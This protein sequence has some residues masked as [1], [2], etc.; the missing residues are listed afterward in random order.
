MI[1]ERVYA[2]FTLRN[3]IPVTV[4]HDRTSEKSSCS[5]AVKTGAMYDPLPGIAHITE[6]AVFLGSEKYPVENAYK[7]F[8]NK[9]G[10]SSNAGTSMEHT[11]YKFAV[12]QA[13]FDKALDIFSQFFKSPLFSTEAMCREIMA[14]D[15]EDSKNRIIDSRRLLQVLKHQV[16]PASEYAKFSTGNLKTLVY[17]DVEK[18]GNN[19][20]N[21]I[22]SFHEEHYLPEHM[23]VALV[24]PQSVEE[25]QRLAEEHFSNVA[26]AENEPAAADATAF[27]ATGKDSSSS[28][29]IGAIRSSPLFVHGR[30]KVIKMRPVKDLR[31]MTIIWELPPSNNLYRED[32]CALLG[33]LLGHKGEGSWFAALQD[34][35]WATSTS[36]GVRTTFHDFTLF[37]TT[38]S[39]TEEGMQ[40]WVSVMAL[41]YKKIEAIR[42]ASDEQLQSVWAEMRAI[43]TLDFQ[44]KQKSSAYELA[45]KL[46]ANMLEYRSDHILSAGWLM[47]EKVD[48]PLLRQFVGSMVPQRSLVFLRSKAFGEDTSTAATAI[49]TTTAAAIGGVPVSLG[50]DDANYI[51][52][53]YAQYEEHCR[54]L[55]PSLSAEDTA[56]TSPPIPSMDLLEAN[57]LSGQYFV[58]MRRF[59]DAATRQ[60]LPDSPADLG[61]G[62][63]GGVY[64]TEPFYG[65]PYFIEDL[66]LDLNAGVFNDISD[67]KVSLPDPNP[68]VCT[69]LMAGIGGDVDAEGD[70]LNRTCESSA[71]DEGEVGS[72]SQMRPVLRPLRSTP[73]KRCTATATM[74]SSTFVSTAWEE[75]RA[76][77]SCVEEVWHSSDEVFR[78]PR[79]I[80]FHLLDSPSCGVFICCMSV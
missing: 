30:G 41:L 50:I 44:Y 4:V 60:L 26:S 72:S 58:D 24:G 12:N 13:A 65:V 39:L 25:L 10:G 45:P 34:K 47:D 78:Q 63:V 18:Y 40:H 74:S 69:E 73:P 52:Q 31:D 23:T 53:S 62:G 66:C 29:K 33:Y 68:Y 80:Y 55:S 14:V 9:N 28:D 20:A 42:G 76:V 35:K 1:D 6:H 71:T 15:S 21:T 79:T 77:G 8:L 59:H 7:D 75:Q 11:T 61:I 3:G 36:A 19:L 51:D 48:V 67:V 46:A 38:V 17:G 16:D 32:P 43:N 57:K 56:S 49:D 2:Q 54:E 22:R 27:I 5:L 64:R 37:E 70:S